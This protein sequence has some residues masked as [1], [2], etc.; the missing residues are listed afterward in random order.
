MLNPYKTRE[1]GA[2]HMPRQPRQTSESGHLHLIVRGIG[3]QALFEE[4]ADYQFYLGILR[5]YARETGVAVCAYCL[6]ENHV[7]LLARDAE[8]R[9]PQLMKKLGVSYS[10]YFNKKYERCGHLFQD[11]Y[12]SEAIEDDAYLLTA[13]RYI[14]NNPAKA[15][16]CP[17]AA[18]AWSSYA[19]YDQPESFV[20]TA[21]L[22][23]LIGDRAQLD[24]FLAGEGGSAC[25]E[26]DKRDEVWQQDL[27]RSILGTENGMVLQ[28]MDRAAR[29][30]A[31]HRL[32][33]AGLTVRRIERLTGIGRNI[34][35]RAK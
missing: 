2:N 10:A 24:A 33:E 1:G 27:L 20:D 29:N 16:I 21:L 15:G 25:M 19:Q 18:Y 6:M 13:F 26:Y 23:G 22:R 7:H 9:T 35:Q 5:R 28:N 4:G 11:R 14:L 31:L 32:K 30:D 34:I 3:R 12:L 8:G 17:A